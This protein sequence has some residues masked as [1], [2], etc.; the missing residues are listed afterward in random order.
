MSKMSN[1]FIE[2]VI[3]EAEDTRKIFPAF[4]SYHE[5]VAVIMEEMDELW[6]L[7]KL[8]PN[9]AGLTQKEYR[10]MMRSEAKQISAMC[11]R[12]AEELCGDDNE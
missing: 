3:K 1:K 7:V 2:E 10:K 8:N 6:D 5:G 12:Y 4:N 9:K 11:L